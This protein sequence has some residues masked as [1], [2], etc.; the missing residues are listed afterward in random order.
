MKPQEIFLG[1]YDVFGIILP[2]AVGMFLFAHAKSGF[3]LLRPDEGWQWSAGERWL[4]LA[5]C[6]YLLGHLYSSIGAALEKLF[7][8]RL[9]K[10]SIARD[11][12]DQRKRATAILRKAFTGCQVLEK[13]A[14]Y[15]GRIYLQLHGPEHVKERIERTRVIRRFFRNIGIAVATASPCPIVLSSGNRPLAT[16][17]ALAVASLLCA[18]RYHGI[19]KSYSRIV[20]DYVAVVALERAHSGRTG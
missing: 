1:M 6:A 5:L 3:P 16:F 12:P 4:L 8:Y 15:W 9:S 14:R 11:H 13:H 10:K 19:Q 7:Y 2:G 17:A 18:Y 20:F